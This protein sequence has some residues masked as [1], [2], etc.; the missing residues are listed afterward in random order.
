M[1]ADFLSD[2]PGKLRYVRDF[3]RHRVPT[4]PT[5][6]MSRLYVVETTPTPTGAIADHRLALRPSEVEAFARAVA[7]GL[8]VGVQTEAGVGSHGAM[9]RRR[10]A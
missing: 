2:L 9:G 8:G 3:S 1:D 7:A 4:R 6:A 5:T 10:G